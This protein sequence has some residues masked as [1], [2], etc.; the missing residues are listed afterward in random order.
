MDFRRWLA[1]VAGGV[2]GALLVA[3][4]ALLWNAASPG[5]LIRF[6]GGVSAQEGLSQSAQQAAGSALAAWQPYAGKDGYNPAC[7][8]RLHLLISPDQARNISVD[9]SRYAGDAAFIYPTVVNVGFL[10]AVILESGRTIVVETSDESGAACPHGQGS[11][12]NLP[13]MC[14]DTKI[15]RRC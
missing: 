12:S 9:L 3:L 1:A 11:L 14:F 8:Y 4:T 6:V 5:G 15:E 13:G 7:D 2:A 10:Q